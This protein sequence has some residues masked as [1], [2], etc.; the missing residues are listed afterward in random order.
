MGHCRFSFHTFTYIFMKNALRKQIRTLKRTFCQEQLELFSAEIC[1]KLLSD[2]AIADAKVVLAYYALPDEVSMK[3]LI[4][5]LVDA[6]KLVLLPEVVSETDMVLR[7]YHSDS[8]LKVG[9]YGILEP[10]GKVFSKYELIDLAL[11]PGMAFDKDGHRLGRGKGYYDRFFS[12][13]QEK[14]GHVPY[15]IGVCFPFQLVD[16]VPTDKHDFSVDRVVCN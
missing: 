16:S 13:V 14:S 5:S 11:V 3:Q 7:E 9:A 8:D 10:T 4:C 15:S 6:G 12:K 2:S 1:S